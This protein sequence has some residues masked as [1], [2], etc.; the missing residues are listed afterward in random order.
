M[1]EAVKDKL[2]GYY[3]FF[4]GLKNHENTLQ[5]TEQTLFKFSVVLVIGFLFTARNVGLQ[6]NKKKNELSWQTCYETGTKLPQKRET[7][8]QLVKRGKN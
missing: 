6:A 3:C 1:A 7:K 8:S 5:N 4:Y 2:Y